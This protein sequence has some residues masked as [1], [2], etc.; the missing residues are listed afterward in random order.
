MD[1]INVIEETNDRNDAMGD[2]VN[3]S[4]LTLQ[5]FEKEFVWKDSGFERTIWF[6][7]PSCADSGYGRNRITSDPDETIEE[8]LVAEELEIIEVFGVEF[9]K[10]A[11]RLAEM[12]IIGDSEESVWFIGSNGQKVYTRTEALETGKG[13]LNLFISEMSLNSL[14]A[15]NDKL[16]ESAVQVHRFFKER[17]DKRWNKLKKIIVDAATEARTEDEVKNG[18]NIAIENVKKLLGVNGDLSYFMGTFVMRFYWAVIKARPANDA[19]ATL[20]KWLRLKS[21]Q[22]NVEAR[23]DYTARIDSAE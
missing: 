19:E 13:L 21:I 17:K 8:L 7:K 23:K 11:A 5:D 12:G 20:I 9:Y 1:G 3:P 18:V 14:C 22:K 2:I 15:G 4:T 6:Y 16:T 10:R